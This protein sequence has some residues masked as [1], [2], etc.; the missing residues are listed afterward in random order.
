MRLW[1]EGVRGKMWRVVR[2]MYRTVQSS[3]LVDGEQTEM[4]ELNMG[5]RQ[6]CV[7][8]PVLFSFFI[9]GLAKEIKEKTAGVCVGNAQVRLLKYAGDI[10]LMS[11][12]K[13]DLQKMLDIVTS[14]SK[15]WRFR[16]NPKKGK[17]EVMIFGRKPRK[18]KE[19]RKWLGCKPSSVQSMHKTPHLVRP[20]LSWRRTS[21]SA[22]LQETQREVCSRGEEE[23]DAGVGNGDERR[24]VAGHRLL[25]G[26]EC[27]CET[28]A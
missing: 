2:E 7:M 6:G 11:D 24:G 21:R 22:R 27:A 5:V 9:N 14:Y 28:C 23:D 3:V 18:T 20:G 15:K 4:F 19:G 8:S 25:H 12:R 17:S 10:V 1:D 16:L 13:R 26:V